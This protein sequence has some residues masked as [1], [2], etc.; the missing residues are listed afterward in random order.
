M[1]KELGK[2]VTQ[3]VRLSYLNV[4]EPK[5]HEEGDKPKYSTAIIIDKD[6]KKTLNA[7]KKAVKE[8][9]AEK[10]DSV[11]GGKTKGLKT[12]LRD[13]DEEREEPEYEGTMFLNAS[14][15][16]R[17]ILLDEDKDP[18]IDERDKL[19]SGCYARVSLRLYA[20][21]NKGNKGVAVGLNAVM[22]MRDGE[23]LGSTYTED[24]AQSDFDDDFDDDIM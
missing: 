9:I 3:E 15:F 12:P 1:A 22:K 14:S 21:N 16:Q 4:Y 8:V 7:I 13:G 11:F 17:P 24:M 2:V 19:Y 6:D 18:I 5:A 20:F 23:P 10:K